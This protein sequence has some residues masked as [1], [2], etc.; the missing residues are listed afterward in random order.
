MTGK[1]DDRSQNPYRSPA[2]L[3]DG[4]ET[5]A[6][7]IGRRTRDLALAGL[8]FGIAYGAATGAAITACLE[9]VQG[10]AW[11]ASVVAGCEL[12]S[13]FDRVVMG[14]GSYFAGVA[15]FGGFLGMISG[16]VLGPLQGVMTAHLPSPPRDRLVRFGAFCWAIIAAIWCLLID[17]AIL[18]TEERRWP[19]YVALVLAPLAAGFGGV[20]VASKLASVGSK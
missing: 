6:R 5:A 11:L 12:P 7:G 8:F 14:L 9:F 10:M 19:L 3:E 20:V 2:G 17:Q 1:E 4:P 18:S 15:I 16:A 13:D